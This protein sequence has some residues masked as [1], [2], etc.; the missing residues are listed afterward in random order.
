VIHLEA[1]VT[2]EEQ[3]GAL[4]ALNPATRKNRHGVSAAENG[5]NVGPSGPGI[6]SSILRC[7]IRSVLE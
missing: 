4:T 1:D 5:R 6:T 2:V 7:E 3:V